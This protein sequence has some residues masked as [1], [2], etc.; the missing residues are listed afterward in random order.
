MNAAA[1]RRAIVDIGSNSIRLVVFGGPPRAPVV[2]FNEKLMAGL[3]RGVIATGALSAG[4]IKTALK[5]LAR[6]A[7]LLRE[8]DVGWCR[9]VATA[10]V[11]EAAN[12]PEFL[13]RIAQL[14]LN[15]ELLD[16]NAEAAAA[17][18]GVLCALPGADGLV[19]DL[20]GGSLE[21]VRVRG[22]EVGE[23]LSLPLG[24]L[25][26]AALRA[27]GPDAVRKK[28]T[29]ALKGTEW[30][31]ECAGKPLYLVGGSWRA[32]ARVHQFRSGYPLAVLGNFAMPPAAIRPLEK[33]LRDT[34]R[35]LAK[36]VPGIGSGRADLL[37]DAATILAA[38]TARI[39][40]ER[41]V[42]C[43][44]GLR[45]GLLFEA[46]DAE[47][48]ARDPLLE[49]V[50]YAVDPVQPFAA[51][52]QALLRWLEPLFGSSPSTD[53]PPADPS[54]SDHRLIEA[55]ARLRGTGWES[56]PDFRAADG[57]ELALHGQWIG[58]D[59]RDRALMAQALY[60]ALGGRAPGP[61][62][63]AQLASA[64][65]LARAA[66]WGHAMRLAQALSGGAPALLERTALRVAGTTLELHLPRDLAALANSSLA[67]RSQRLASALSLRGAEI[68]IAS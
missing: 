7:L 40:P 30:L 60:L 65:D 66:S 43:A 36:S 5:G 24:V 16:G 26:I 59:G 50:R 63:L 68:R 2:L 52:P 12:G 47:T 23:R 49:G 44:F 48:R 39:A 35:T 51:Y 53:L 46:L 58:V 13:E 32:L 37:G 4:S 29:A 19:A 64:P 55:V 34:R 56:N 11:R 28:L 15:A 57:A 1:T 27:G 21:L 14:G 6:F 18:Y 22:G 62:I 25:R 38:L 67:R 20:G 45:E 8:M 33:A 3:G 54:Q 61:A 10:A 17:G 9:V 42:T 31:R 41:L